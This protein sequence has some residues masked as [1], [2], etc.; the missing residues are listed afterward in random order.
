MDTDYGYPDERQIR[1]PYSMRQQIRR[2]AWWIG[3]YFLFKCSLRPM[4]GWRRWVLR[5]YGARLADHV[6]IQRSVRIEFPWNLEMGRYSSIGE[7][8]WIYNLERIQIGE[9]TTVSQRV[10]LCT[11]SHDYAR[12]EMPLITRPIS[13][14]RGVWLAADAYVG[15]GICIG[16][17]AVIGARSVVT[18][19]MPE[20]MV[21]AG[22]PC[23]PIKPRLTE[24]AK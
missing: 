14:G 16:D 11:G 13:V 15:P 6:C 8:A 19:D 3:E 18:K 10:F 17:Y 21:C 1:N 22:H 9:F 24:T 4:Y 20:K 7:N 5:L 12:P 23:R 2:M